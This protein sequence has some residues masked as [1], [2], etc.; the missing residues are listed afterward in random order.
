MKYL[1]FF[2]LSLV[3]L[4]QYACVSVISVLGGVEEEEEEEE[5]LVCLCECHLCFGSIMY[6]C[7]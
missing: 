4:C 2:L 1:S 3:C 7:L 6:R 5:A